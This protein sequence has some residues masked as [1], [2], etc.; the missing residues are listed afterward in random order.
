MAAGYALDLA[1]SSMRPSLLV[2][3]FLSVPL[4][5]TAAVVKGRIRVSAAAGEAVM[6]GAALSATAAYLLWLA[7]PSLLLVLEHVAA[8]LSTARP[9]PLDGGPDLVTVVT[10]L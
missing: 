8:L 2:V 3:V 10:I 1:G 4:I 6:F 5:A 7:S 9:V